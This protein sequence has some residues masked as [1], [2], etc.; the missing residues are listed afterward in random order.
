MNQTLVD[1]VCPG[2]N[3]GLF[4]LISDTCRAISNHDTC[5]ETQLTEQV[6][7]IRFH[8][9]RLSSSSSP[10]TSSIVECDLTSHV[11]VVSHPICPRYIPLVW[12]SGGGRH[13]AHSA[14]CEVV[15]VG[16]RGVVVVRRDTSKQADKLIGLSAVTESSNPLKHLLHGKSTMLTA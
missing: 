13:V 11:R 8:P 3:L 9:S 5:A 15:L 7:C 10:G 6:W 1:K 4:Q 2:H 14:Q 12:R 16:V